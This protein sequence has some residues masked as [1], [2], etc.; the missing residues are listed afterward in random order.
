[1]MAPLATGLRLA[2]ETAGC[3]RRLLWGIAAAMLITLV[4]S[5]WFTLHLAYEHGGVNLHRQFFRTFPQYPA[6]F[7]LQQLDSPA[8]PD[9]NGSLWILGGGA[10]MGLLMVGRHHF[11]GWPLHPLGF[12]VAAGW[13]MSVLWSSIMLAWLI[14]SLVLRLGGARTFER[15]KPFFLGLVLGQ[16]VVGGLWLAIDS[17]TGTV[18]NVIPVF[19]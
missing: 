15:T 17:L 12:A 5:V 13:T 8:G 16:L 4:V 3:R 10:V 14:K 6:T 1:M 7:A 2:S 11:V 18:G 19:Y 9:L